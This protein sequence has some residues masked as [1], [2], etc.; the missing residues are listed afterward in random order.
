MT[1]RVAYP[2]L[3]LALAALLLA[4]GTAPA[5]G[6]VTVGSDLPAPI[7]DPFTCTSGC[8]IAATSLPGRMVASPIDGVLVRWRARVS[9]PSQP[10]S[11]TIELRTLRPA[12]GGSYTAR[13]SDRG[14]PRANGAVNTFAARLPVRRGDLI[15]LDLGSGE[16][17]G[18]VPRFSEL[19]T[20][21]PALAAGE[22]RGPAS[23]GASGSELLYNADIEP[24]GDGDGYGD[25]TQ[26]QCPLLS[27]KKTSPCI[28][29]LRL[30]HGG[31]VPTEA[32][33]GELIRYYIKVTNGGHRSVGITLDAAIA[34]QLT[35]V[36]A[37][38]SSGSCGPRSG[39]HLICSLG[40]LPRNKSRTVT[41]VL[42]VDGMGG[43]A[44]AVSGFSVA[45]LVPERDLAN[46]TLESSVS[47]V[48]PRPCM[49]RRTGGDK[50]DR[51]LGGLA[52]D[53]LVGGRGDD[54]LFGRAGTDCLSGGPGNDRL[55]GGSGA[56]RLGGGPGYDRLKGGRGNDRLDGG[57]HDD[58]I[59]GGPGR[60]AFMGGEGNDRINAR[61]RR[62]ERIDCGPGRD[63]AKVDRK[64]RV[65]RCERVLRPKR[66]RG[67]KH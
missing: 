27:E 12:G 45:G 66:A 31:A 13:G 7:G 8:T 62:R 11:D 1:A 4:F 22:T 47:I 59:I 55:D 50:D 61:D 35:V 49:I 58:R 64:D 29:D 3:G 5:L 48:A 32:V 38:V 52:P 23:A 39:G 16:G 14:T 41:F 15:G 18:A 17:I 20:F 43:G 28:A 21:F 40:E 10:L 51:I 30:S 37:S 54:R 63:R 46:N 6:A 36:S 53:M 34:R 19:A 26:D 44:Q 60:D 65:V 42:R 2:G 25:E 9:I 33:M 24:D 56:D 67:R 57:T